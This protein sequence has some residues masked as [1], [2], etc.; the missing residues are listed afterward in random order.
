[1]PPKVKITKQDIIKSAL[2]LIRSGGEGAI[3]ARSIAHELGC[4]TQP[5]FSNFASME[6]LQSAVIAAAYELYLGFIKLEV[7]SGKYPQ[8]KAFGMA[9]VRFAKDERELFKLLF[10]RDRTGEDMSTSPDFNQSVQIIMDANKIS[11]EDAMMMHLEMWTCV[12]G[13]G[14]MIAT[15]F[16]S[17]EWDLISNMLSDVYQG[18]RIRHIS[19]GND[20]ESN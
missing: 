3:N 4:S 5:V 10:M 2:D 9:Y 11:Y 12:H 13:I 17:P 20:N 14:T 1:M 7:E 8:Y 16:W 6:E 18:I 19:E 15:S